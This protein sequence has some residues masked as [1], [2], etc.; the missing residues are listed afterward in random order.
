MS[1]KKKLI[2]FF[3]V[4]F[5]LVLYGILKDVLLQINGVY[6][7]CEIKSARRVRTTKLVEVTFEYKGKAY[8]REVTIGEQT[9]ITVGKRFFMKINSNNP[10]GNSSIYNSDSV[11][12]CIHS[13]PFE[14][15]ENIP[16]CSNN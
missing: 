7:V 3:G 10:F 12:I 1:N 2:L 15:W 8:L 6:V 4:L 11:P 9:D 16:T 13:N 14:G 5:I